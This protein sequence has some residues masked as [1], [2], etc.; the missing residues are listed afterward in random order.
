MGFSLR[1]LGCLVHIAER[2]FTPRQ[3]REFDLRV[4]S[5]LRCAMAVT[6]NGKPITM[7]PEIQGARYLWPNLQ[8]PPGKTTVTV[9]AQANEKV[10]KDSVVWE[11]PDALP[12]KIAPH[13]EEIAPRSEANPDF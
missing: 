13:S 1:F 6:I 12:V 3:F 2:R 5:N 8:A 7:E 9:I 11:L 10:F 4:Y